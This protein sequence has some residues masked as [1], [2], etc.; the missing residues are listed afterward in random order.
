MWLKEAKDIS[1]P[2]DPVDLADYILTRGDEPCG[3]TVPEAILK[4][5]SW[6]EKVAEFDQASRATAGRLVWA[7]KDT[8]V[9]RLSWKALVKVWASLP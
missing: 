8:V 6:M 4:A 1:P 5:I 3:R 2:G 9:E 7:V